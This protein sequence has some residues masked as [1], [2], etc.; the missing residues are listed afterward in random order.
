MQFHCKITFKS[1]PAPKEMPS[2]LLRIIII[3]VAVSFISNKLVRKNDINK[4]RCLKNAH[5]QCAKI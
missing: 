2:A 3:L 1:D 5:E 4:R